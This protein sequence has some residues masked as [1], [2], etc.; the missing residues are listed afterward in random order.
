M[1]LYQHSC[2][3]IYHNKSSIIWYL[4]NC[5]SLHSRHLRSEGTHVPKLSLQF[6]NSKCVHKLECINATQ[7]AIFIKFDNNVGQ[8]KDSLS[9]CDDH[10]IKSVCTFV[11]YRDVYNLISVLSSE[12]VRWLRDLTRGGAF[13]EY[14]SEY[15][16]FRYFTTN[17]ETFEFM[18]YLT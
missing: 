17:F 18:I 12:D 6:H 3:L 13:S 11:N 10:M 7:Q 9:P 5:S 2:A 8:I 15:K 1:Y 14:F 16:M 4:S